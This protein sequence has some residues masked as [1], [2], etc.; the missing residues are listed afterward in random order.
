MSTMGVLGGLLGAA[1]LLASFSEY[2]KTDTQCSPREKSQFKLFKSFQ[3]KYLRVYLILML[4]DWLQGTNMY[5]L[6]Q[7]YG[8]DIGTLFLI[9]FASSGIFG[10]FA[11]SFIDQLGRKNGCILYCVLELIINGIEHVNDFRLLLFGRVLGGIST[12]LLFSTFDSWMIA[13]HK[14]RQFQDKWLARTFSLAAVGNGVTAVLAG[15][16]AQVSSIYMGEIGPFRLS[17]VLTAL[18]LFLI[19]DWEENY[20]DVKSEWRQNLVHAVQFLRTE[21]QALVLGLVNSFFEGAMYTFVFMWV[22]AL[23]TLHDDPQDSFPTVRS[24]AGDMRSVIYLDPPQSPVTF[25]P[26]NCIPHSYILVSSCPIASRD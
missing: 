3:Y 12:S 19:L 21:P 2:N 22:P 17:I 24:T 26:F 14:K 5:T 6:Y 25:P 9:G 8:V 4:A 11:G 7:S 10:T 1:F 23:Q 18:G 13:E 15:L 20:G 16:L